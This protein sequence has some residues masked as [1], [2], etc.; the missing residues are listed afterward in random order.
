MRRRHLLLKAST[1]KKLLDLKHEAE[2]HHQI[3]TI[4]KIR[5][6]LMNRQ[7]F[8]LL[9]G[10]EE[11]GDQTSDR[12]ADQLSVSRSRVN[13]WLRCFEV[14]G[15]KSIFSGKRT[16][17]PTK[18]TRDQRLWLKKVLRK[19]PTQAGFDSQRWNWKILDQ[20]LKRECAISYHQGHLRRILS[21]LNNIRKNKSTSSHG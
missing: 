17:R 19:S 11:I 16:G 7:T 13:E 8:R 4:N 6:I 14:N 18:M 3:G 12:I 10:P 20:L 2:T 1:I 5:A 9:D 21:H 15:L